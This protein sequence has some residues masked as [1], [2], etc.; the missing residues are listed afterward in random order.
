MPPADYSGNFKL[1]FKVA[2]NEREAKCFI[3]SGLFCGSR[4]D[5]RFAPQ[6][7]SH[8]RLRERFV[9][10]DNFEIYQEKFMYNN[11]NIISASKRSKS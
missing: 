2:K 3:I 8:S 9:S 11:G 1:D 7:I 4:L 10:P 5:L 6:S